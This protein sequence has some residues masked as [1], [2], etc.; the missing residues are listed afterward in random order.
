MPEDTGICEP[1]PDGKIV[2]LG[3]EFYRQGEI[4]KSQDAYQNCGGLGLQRR[5]WG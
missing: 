4:F 5:I 1:G 3:K 2:R